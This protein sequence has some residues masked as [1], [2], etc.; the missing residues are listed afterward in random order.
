M[1]TSL[2]F[3]FVKTGSGSLP[4]GHLSD[5]VRRGRSDGLLSDGEEE[6][7]GAAHTDPGLHGER[8][9]DWWRDDDDKE[10]EEEE[11]EGSGG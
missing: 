3:S 9:G 10:E 1:L 6:L 11:E 7:W 4:P 5:L 8:G 2:S